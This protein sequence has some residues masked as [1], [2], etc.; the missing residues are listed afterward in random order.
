MDRCLV[1]FPQ[2]QHCE[3][4]L[5]L[6]HDE[7]LQSTEHGFKS[8]GFFSAAAPHAA[9]EPPFTVRVRDLDPEPHVLVHDVQPL[10]AP[11]LHIGG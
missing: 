11:S 8:H 2:A 10:H 1:R 7:S 3:H 5:Q 9:T 6:V 4:A